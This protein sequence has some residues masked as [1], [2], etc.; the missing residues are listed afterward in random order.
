M[1]GLTSP[2]G[3]FSVECAVTNKVQNRKLN[4][5][6][7]KVRILRA[8]VCTV[9]WIVAVCVSLVFSCINCSFVEIARRTAYFVIRLSAIRAFSFPPLFNTTRVLR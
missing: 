6:L 3:S 1:E 2:D 5:T 9:V 4:A 7:N 8:K